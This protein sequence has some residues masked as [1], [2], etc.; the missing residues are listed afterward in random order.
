MASVMARSSSSAVQGRRMKR[1]KRMGMYRAPVISPHGSNELLAAPHVHEIA[2]M[3]PDQRHDDLVDH[4][5]ESTPERFV[6]FV[7]RMAER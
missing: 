4:A 2:G 3:Q 7:N 1:R 5:F 6:A